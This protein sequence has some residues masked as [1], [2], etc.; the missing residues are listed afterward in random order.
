MKEPEE[1]G[2]R[3]EFLLRKAGS[4]LKAAG[5]EVRLVSKTNGEM[6]GGLEKMEH[7]GDQNL[8]QVGVCIFGPQERSLSSSSPKRCPSS[9]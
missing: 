4:G 5:D 7:E 1:G 3:S 6:A 2:L 8:M 9:N